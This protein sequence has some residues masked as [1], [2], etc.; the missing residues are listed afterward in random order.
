MSLALLDDDLDF[1]TKFLVALFNL[2]RRVLDPRVEA[3]ANVEKRHVGFG[4]GGEIIER[5]RFRQALGMRGFF[6]LGARVAEQKRES[7]PRGGR[8]SLP[9]GCALSRPAS[10]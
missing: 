4:Q 7:K 5:L 8:A 9:V 3:A 1:S 10:D 2:E 6:A